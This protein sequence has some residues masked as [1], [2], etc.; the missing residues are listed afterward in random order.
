MALCLDDGAHDDQTISSLLSYI[1]SFLIIFMLFFLPHHVEIL[2][3]DGYDRDL[4]NFYNFLSLDTFIPSFISSFS[5]SYSLFF[6][7]SICKLR[8]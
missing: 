7:R 4:A 5:S 3:P 6:L 1:F 8:W 2:R